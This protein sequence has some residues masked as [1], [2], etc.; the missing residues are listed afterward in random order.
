[1]L[2]FS[3]PCVAI[4]ARFFTSIKSILKTHPDRKRSRLRGGLRAAI[5]TE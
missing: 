5:G 2:W 4:S 3:R 1:M